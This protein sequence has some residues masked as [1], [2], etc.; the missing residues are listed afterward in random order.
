MRGS[1]VYPAC[2]RRMGIPSIPSI[3]QCLSSCSKQNFC[4]SL[5]LRSHPY[6]IR[7]RFVCEQMQQASPQ[8]IRFFLSRV[9]YFSLFYSNGKGSKREVCDAIDIKLNKCIMSNFFNIAIERR[10]MN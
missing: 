4:T 2:F 6:G 10:F 7:H 3:P 5:F 1:S 9:S 8:T